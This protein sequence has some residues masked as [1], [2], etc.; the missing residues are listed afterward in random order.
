MQITW[1]GHSGFR[2]A[3]A[4]QVL[5]IDPWLTGNPSFPAA[6]E[7]EAVAGATT[8]LITHAHGDHYTDAVRL[9]ALTH[10]PILAVH[11]IAEVIDHGG[12]GSAIGFGRGGAVTRGGVK[13][14]MVP[15]SHSNSFDNDPAN[16]RMAGAECGY[17]I[18]GEGHVIYVTGDTG[19]MADM[20][21]MGEY[22]APDIGILCCGGHYTMDM[23]GAA[24]A[25]R[26]FFDFK[27]VIPC[28]YKTFGLLAQ[29][30]DA[31]VAGLPGV[32]V[33][34]PGVM[35]MVAIPAK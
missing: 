31:L 3:I 16:L 7:A 33:L 4:D 5:L 9:S 8:I 15:A 26:R 12:V 19:I 6:R 25:A 24:W 2:I 14:S 32:Q 20:G 22:Y 1:L 23:A 27:T 13:I 35:E 17:M 28:H 29:S 18:A 11:E 21:W 34:V 30:A 10:A